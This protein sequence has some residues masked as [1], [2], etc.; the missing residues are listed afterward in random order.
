MRKR[1]ATQQAPA[2]PHPGTPLPEGAHDWVSPPP[3][4]AATLADRVASERVD[5]LRA[6]VNAAVAVNPSKPGT[7]AGD[8]SLVDEGDRLRVVI[9]RETFSPVKYNTFDV[10]PLE[11]TVTVRR[12]ESAADAFLRARVVLEQL[13]DAELATRIREFVDHLDE[14]RK[15]VRA[16]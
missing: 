10:G 16:E 4:T 5:P 7:P 3:A 6:A 8:P 11:M 12:G 15:R 14:A 13:F 2:K 1:E 9:G